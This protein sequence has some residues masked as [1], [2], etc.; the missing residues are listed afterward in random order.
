MGARDFY[1]YDG[2]SAGLGVWTLMAWDN[3]QYID[4]WRRYYMGWVAPVD[5][6]SSNTYTIN[7]LKV[8]TK[9]A[10]FTESGLSHQT[11]ISCLKTG[12]RYG[13]ILHFPVQGC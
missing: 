8:L 3:K 12:K 9:V 7:R 6:S 13:G 1:D 4:P 11:N 2:D 10:L 5:V